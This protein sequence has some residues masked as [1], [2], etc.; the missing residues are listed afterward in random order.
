MTA[1][2]YKLA[3]AIDDYYHRA[4]CCGVSEDTANDLLNQELLN[5]L[6]TDTTSDVIERASR[7]LPLIVFG[8]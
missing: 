3:R 8:P 2:L 5:R 1:Y 4:K 7:K 6:S